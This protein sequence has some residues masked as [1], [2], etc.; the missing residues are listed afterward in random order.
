MMH[1]G[2]STLVMCNEGVQLTCE[3]NEG[4]NFASHGAVT[5]MGSSSIIP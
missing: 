5:L 1:I 4:V 2:G 3:M